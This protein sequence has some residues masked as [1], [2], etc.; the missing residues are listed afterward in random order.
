VV[1]IQYVNASTLDT[2]ES[3]DRHTLYH[4]HNHDA[5]DPV[6]THTHTHTHTH[7][8]RDSAEYSKQGTRLIHEHDDATAGRM[9]TDLSDIA[10]ASPS[11]FT[12]QC[13]SFTTQA[14]S[15]L[16]QTPSPS[17]AP[18]AATLKR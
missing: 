12:T 16:L 5:R 4:T 11:V 15:P 8:A 13:T 1:R 18:V 2:R 10:L 3:M 9:A 14:S 6:D 7:D 17:P